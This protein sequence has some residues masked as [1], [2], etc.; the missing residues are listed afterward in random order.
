M[1][2]I[3]LQRAFSAMGGAGA[4]SSTRHPGPPLIG[5]KETSPKPA[6]R[7]EPLNLGAPPHPARRPGEGGHGEGAR[8]AGEG[9]PQPPQAN[10]P[11]LPDT[12]LVIAGHGTPLNPDSRKSIE[13]QVERIA[14]RGLFAEVHPAFLEEE[15]RIADI[16]KFVAAPRIVVVPF[17]LSDGLHVCEDIPV[18]LGEDEAVVQRRLKAGEWPWR[19]PTERAG[20]TIFY[21]PGVGSEPRIADVIVERVRA[22][23]GGNRPG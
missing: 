4:L 7:I 5:W 17:F 21:T 3:I 6:S 22:A 18:L 9:T 2:E 10:S 12:A 11:S 1:T 8:R 16:P 14:V 19:N 20:K 23:V 13:Q 15:P